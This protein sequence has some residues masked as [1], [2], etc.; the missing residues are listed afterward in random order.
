MAVVCPQPVQRSRCPPSAAVRQ[1]T[2]ASN[3][4]WC[5]Q[6]IHL[7]LCSINACP[8]Q[9]TMSAISRRGRLMN[10]ACAL[11][12]KR[13]SVHR[14]GF[15]KVCGEAM[16]QSVRM[17]VPV[18][19][20]GSF[21]SNL[22]GTP[23]DLGGHRLA[24]CVPTV[25]G[26]EPLLRLAPESA[27][28]SAQRIEQLRAEHYIAV[29][30]SLALPDVNHHPLAVDV[31]DLQVGRFC[32]A[33][34][35]GIE[36]HQKD[37]MKGGVRGVDQARDLLLAEYLGKMTNLLRVGRLGDAPAAL[38][39]VNVEETQSRQTQDYGVRTVLQLGEEH[40]LILANVFRAKL[41]RRAAKVPAEVCNTVQVA[42][43]GCFGE[44]AALQLLKHEL[45]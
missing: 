45:T 36:R 30:A 42:A 41:I 11:P 44:V 8:A 1:R 32:A 14:A 27:P 19:E 43:D 22:A 6:L 23:Q 15:E 31:A 29:L 20:A 40:R 26:Q 18:I 16:S 10:C 25:A 5:C 21:G 38:Q 2:M 37:A 9:R 35:G 34:A 39:H 28:V 24:G 7:R 3:T 17:D 12:L 13:T 4:F 33:C